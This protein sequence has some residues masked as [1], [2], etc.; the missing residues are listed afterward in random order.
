[1]SIYNDLYNFDNEINNLNLL[2]KMVENKKNRQK[3][4]ELKNNLKKLVYLFI[5]ILK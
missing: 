2:E 1:V 4:L 5:K 3:K